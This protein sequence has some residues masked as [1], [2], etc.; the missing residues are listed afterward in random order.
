MLDKRFVLFVVLSFGIL[1][2]WQMI[3]R[4]FNPLPDPAPVAEKQ[5]D[6][7]AGGNQ[8]EQDEPGEDQPAAPKDADAGPE[9]AEMVAGQPD[10]EKAAAAE[11]DAAAM[12]VHTTLG[13]LDP[14]SK[15]RLLV[16]INSRGAAV[17]TIEVTDRQY[18][19]VVDR[20]GYLGYLALRDAEETDEG[21]NETA[22]DAPA[23]D[24]K[25]GSGCVVGVVGPGTPAA[26][27]GLKAGDVIVSIKDKPVSKTADFFRELRKTRPRQTIELGIAGQAAP[28]RVTLIRRP[29]AIVQPE[30]QTKTLDT[31]AGKSHD[32]LSF[33]FTLDSIGERKYKELVNDKINLREA[34]WEITKQEAEL[35]ELS[36]AVPGTK[37]RAVK[38]YRLVPGESN[39]DDDPLARAYHL[40]LE[41][42]LQNQGSQATEVA[43]RLD[44]PTGLPTAGWWFANK[45][46]RDWWTSGL[47]DVARQLEQGKFTLTSSTIIADEDADEDDENFVQRDKSVDYM[48]VDALY[49][50]SVLIPQNTETTSD[51]IMESRP[52]AIGSL[53][54][55]N[56]DKLPEKLTNVT[57]R[58]ISRQEKL[59]PGEKLTHSYT[60]FAGPKQR[61]L[62]TQYGPEGRVAERNL[63]ELIYYGLWFFA[64]FAK[65]LGWILHL[66]SFVGN[67]GLAIILLTIVVR[68]CMYPISKKQALNAIKMQELAPEMKRISEKYKKDMQKRSQALQEMYKKHNYSPLSGC[69]PLFIQMPIFIGLY[70]SLQANIE[71]RGAPLFGE[72]IRWADNLSAP[73]M[74]FRWDSW[75]FFSGYTGWLGPYFNILPIFTVLL[76]LWQQK[77]FTPP[78]T[79][80]QSA[81][82]QKMMKYMMFFMG[83]MFF[84]VPSGLC[85]Y[86]IASSLWGIGERKLLP[87]PAPKD[88][89][90]VKT[91]PP[92][93]ERKPVE[94]SEKAAATKPNDG[95]GK[96]NNG[97]AAGG[98]KKNRSKKKG[99]R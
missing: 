60:V 32:P 44:G 26:A 15:F 57:C 47:R 61:E 18:L 36:R 37:L 64:L 74:L 7:A 2:G 42:E 12:P 29:V 96:S 97:T 52:V 93:K 59:A 21:E 68:C 89:A 84:K 30:Y 83:L 3:Y 11:E 73:D 46:Q 22:E 65:P 94:K 39:V 75:M 40:T 24:K 91:P 31:T 27:A 51:W 19:D 45:V 66:F 54:K 28:L 98:K 85:L 82:T 41:V 70:K 8:Q 17:E 86:F 10:E 58:F 16:T 50:A 62:L 87:K 72:S 55:N 78:P 88:P 13:S 14:A 81:M 25:I 95:G 69:L 4:H 99:K 33:L 34:N 48:G 9:Q 67:Y 63:G 56:K 23:D 20:S 5:D 71:L 49:F 92:G 79:D 76:F 90:A 80:E 43:Y 1:M 35:V 77:L 53:P 38:R 6:E